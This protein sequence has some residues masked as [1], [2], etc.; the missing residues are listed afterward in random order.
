MSGKETKSSSGPDEDDGNKKLYLTHRFIEIER[1]DRE[2]Y[3]SN[4]LQYRP[5]HF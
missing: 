3:L 1:Y 4:S 5:T 2:R